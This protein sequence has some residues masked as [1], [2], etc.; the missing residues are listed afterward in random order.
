[1]EILGLIIPKG[2][3]DVM[4]RIKEHQWKTLFVQDREFRY[5]KRCDKMERKEY[6]GTN[7]SMWVVNE[8]KP[9][10]V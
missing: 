1:M 4:C 8:I 7:I 5:C 3:N 9:T 10:S 2:N 6:F